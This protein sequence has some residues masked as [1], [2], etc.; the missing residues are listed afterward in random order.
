MPKSLFAHPLT[1]PTASQPRGVPLRV[2]SLDA[3]EVPAALS[4]G[5]GI[6]TVNMGEVAPDRG[7]RTMRLG[8]DTSTGLLTRSGNLPVRG[9]PNG[10][11][12]VRNIVGIRVNGSSG[13]D[14][15]DLSGVKSG[16]FGRLDG[17]IDIFGK[18]GDD[19]IAGSM[20]DDNIE[21]GANDDRVKGLGG[22]DRIVGEGGRDTIHGDGDGEAR[23]DGNDRIDG[24]ADDDTLQGGG[25]NDVVV[26]GPGVDDIA[27]G[28]SGHDVAW[29]DAADIRPVY[30][31]MN[32]GF[33]EARSGRPAV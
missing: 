14:V 33:E 24:G 29:F 13:N 18:A 19:A 11:L 8:A 6:L 26:G 7:T 32:R 27:K 2:E 23:T 25:G 3:R 9:T 5:G 4:F 22:S 15:I 16:P 1:P 28:G 12:V 10:Q 30:G 21:A 31:W 17:R 20:F